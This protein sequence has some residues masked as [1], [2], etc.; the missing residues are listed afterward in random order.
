MVNKINLYIEL[1]KNKNVICCHKTLANVNGKLM[2]M[3]FESSDL[4][5]ENGRS[6]S[7]T[8]SLKFDGATFQKYVSK[9]YRYLLTYVNYANI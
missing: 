6:V 5:L 4:D 8:I 1:V 2:K 3:K 7:S 9:L